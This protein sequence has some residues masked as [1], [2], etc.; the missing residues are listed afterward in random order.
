MEGSTPTSHLSPSRSS[1]FGVP[2]PRIRSTPVSMIHPAAPS[3]TISRARQ[4]AKIPAKIAKALIAP[5]QA[6]Q[7]ASFDCTHARSQ[8]SHASNAQAAA[9]ANATSGRHLHQDRVINQ[10]IASLG[11]AAAISLSGSSASDASDNLTTSRDL[12]P[13]SPSPTAHHPRPNSGQHVDPLA[14]LNR[15]SKKHC[16]VSTGNGQVCQHDHSRIPRRRDTPIERGPNRRMTNA[17]STPCP[18]Q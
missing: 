13:E 3:L 18:E 4:P 6:Y 12:L 5:Q 16:P 9:K 10:A 8:R 7:R 11:P 2:D 14:P 17:K 15:A 1:S